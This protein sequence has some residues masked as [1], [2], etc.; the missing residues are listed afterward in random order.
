M[1]THSTAAR[2]HASVGQ[3]PYPPA[4][5]PHSPV[6]HSVCVQAK[7]IQRDTGLR[8]LQLCSVTLTARNVQW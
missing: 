4:A 6:M 2:L 7:S 1:T 8:V 5:W 3:N